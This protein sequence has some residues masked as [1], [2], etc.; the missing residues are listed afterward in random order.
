MV[1]DPDCTDC[2]EVETFQVLYRIAVTRYMRDGLDADLE[3]IDAIDRRL[4]QLELTV[5]R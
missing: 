4:E 2:Q 5:D 3:L 1:S